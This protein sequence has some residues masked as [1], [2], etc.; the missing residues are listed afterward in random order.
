[1][2]GLIS[3]LLESTTSHVNSLAP[4]LSVTAKPA[5]EH[6]LRNLE[7]T[8]AQV[9]EWSLRGLHG[10]GAAMHWASQA[11]ESETDLPI[12]E[13]AAAIQLLTELADTSIDLEKG[14]SLAR[15]ALSEA[16]VE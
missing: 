15:Q 16:R 12:D 5:S 6:N 3:N 14:A 9:A 8:A 2:K 10:I 11:E 4:G 7:F 13:L 1:M